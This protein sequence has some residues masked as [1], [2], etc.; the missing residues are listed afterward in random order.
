MFK[1]AEKESR[2]PSHVRRSTAAQRHLIH[3]IT[4]MPLVCPTYKGIEA[5]SPRPVVGTMDCSLLRD[6]YP[7]GDFYFHAVLQDLFFFPTLGKL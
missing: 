6:Y 4:R 3:V 2:F 7:D 1:R 5:C